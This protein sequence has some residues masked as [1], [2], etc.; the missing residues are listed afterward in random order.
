VRLE[1]ADAVL[2]FVDLQAKQAAWGA[3]VVRRLLSMVG[4]TSQVYLCVAADLEVGGQVQSSL[5]QLNGATP[6]I[7]DLDL[8]VVLLGTV[9]NHPDDLFA[10]ALHVF[11]RGLLLGLR[12]RWGCLAFLGFAFCG[13]LGDLHLRPSQSTL[14]VCVCVCV[15]VCVRARVRVCMY[16]CGCMYYVCTCV[17]VCVHVCVRMY[18]RAWCEHGSC[19]LLTLHQSAHLCGDF[20]AGSSGTSASSKRNKR[21]KNLNFTKRPTRR[22]PVKASGPAGERG[23]DRLDN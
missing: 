22:P 8:T 19:Q 21:N 13:F 6:S 10:S 7:H 23:G 3:L 9:L 17:Y 1:N 18:L 5:G 4:Q 16:G 11:F 2:G 15:C 14:H 12:W 20:D